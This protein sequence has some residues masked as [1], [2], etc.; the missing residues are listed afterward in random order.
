MIAGLLGL[1]C[2]GLSAFAFLGAQ[3]HGES[4][5]R[6]LER[7]SWKPLKTRCSPPFQANESLLARPVHPDLLAPQALLVHLDHPDHL[8]PTSQAMPLQ[9]PSMRQPSNQQK[10]DTSSRKLADGTYDQT[11]YV[12][13]RRWGLCGSRRLTSKWC[14]HRN[15]A[16]RPMHGAPSLKGIGDRA[17]W[18]SSM[19]DDVASTLTVAKL[20]ALCILNDL[21]TSGK[22]E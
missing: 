3:K 4:V 16:L 13:E 10:M 7:G 8:S 21:P 1:V 15:S 18:G 12:Q 14:R 9:K 2:L 19:G 6:M 22:K 5:K 17:G 20:K 11:V